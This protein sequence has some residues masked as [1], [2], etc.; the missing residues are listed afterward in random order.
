[1]AVGVLMAC[2]CRGV[3]TTT[4]VRTD[5]QGPAPELGGAADGLARQQKTG[6]GT[7]VG[8]NGYSNVSV[9]GVH[10]SW[11]RL[12]DLATSSSSSSSNSKQQRCSG[13][14]R[15]GA[16][17]VRMICWSDILGVKVAKVLG[18]KDVVDDK[19]RRKGE[20]RR[21]RENMRNG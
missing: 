8:A 13:N 7:Y 19:R 14:L 12:S 11:I 1:M 5:D 4:A 15:A 18:T 20:E 6:M 21:S 10:E 2:D 17:L 3:S 16:F 9:S